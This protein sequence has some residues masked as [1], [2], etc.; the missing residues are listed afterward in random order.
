M[1][2]KI[3]IIISGG[4]T[5]GHIYPAIA[6][7]QKL[8]QDN[9]IENI[10]YIGCPN[11]MEKDIAA[12]EDI[13]FLPVSVS[14]MPRKV[15]FKFIKWIFQLITASIKAVGYLK[16]Y[17]PN[18]VVGTGG[19]VS[20]PALI[21]A[22]LLN[23][24]FIIHDAD[25]HPGIVSR[26]TAPYAATVSVAFEEAKKF[27]KSDSIFVNGNPVRQTFSSIS[28]NEA[29]AQLNLGSNTKILLIIGGSQGAKSLNDAMKT[30]VQ[31]LVEEH[32]FLVI[33]QT[34]KNKHDQYIEE[35]KSICPEL[36][37]NPNYIV[38]P[39]FDNTA[40]LYAAADLAITRAGSLTLSELCL[41]ALPSI[42]VPYPYAA[43]DHQR[44]NARAMEKSGA[45]VYLDD[46]DCNA[47]NLMNFILDLLNNENKLLKMKDSAKILAKPYATENIVK[48][49]KDIAK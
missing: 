37:S 10:Y 2:N 36:L 4:G 17:K 43:A 47:D 3:N 13:D 1:E 20:G 5:G 38:M 44:Y 42:L 21:A 49:I 31:S 34:G 8:K 25:A 11:N 39:Y 24:P 30:I 45:S 19:Y 41:S 18:V 16:K 14:G 12:Q 32:K 22:K 48:L 46:K 40:L 35:L 9:D 27:I 29:I 26:V 15:S 6:I 28:K 7:A 33:H 23:I